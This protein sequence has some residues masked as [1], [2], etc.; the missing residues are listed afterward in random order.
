MKTEQKPRFKFM[1]SLTVKGLAIAVMTLVMLI[2]GCMVQD[3]IRERQRTRNEAVEKIDAKW[4]YAQTLCGPVLSIPFTFVPSGGKEPVEDIL[5][6]VP[7]TLD[8]STTLLPE[9]RH[10]GIY[11]T[12]LYK[13]ETSIKG[14]F[15]AVVAE[16]FPAGTIHWDRA[17]VRMGVTDLRGI[18][19]NIAFVFDGREYGV[20]TSAESSPV[21]IDTGGNIDGYVNT[22]RRQKIEVLRI[23]LREMKPGAETDFSC[24]VEL[25]GSG[26]INYLPV[27]RTTTVALTGEWPDPG[28]IG[29]YTPEY[30]IDGGSF[31]AKWKVLSFNR[32]IPDTWLGSDET[33]R[34]ASFGATLVD[35]VDIYQQNMRSSKYALMFIALTFVIFFFVEVIG[36]RSI[37]PV[38]YLLVGVALILFYSLLLSISE[39][40]G[41]GWAYLISSAATIG[42]ITA[43]AASIFRN[44]RLTAALSLIL[45]ALYVFMYVILQLEQVALLAGSVGLFVI[46]G[47]IMYFSHRVNWYGEK[48]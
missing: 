4:S 9:E 31:D 8:I 34:T 32:N 43:Y 28:F 14:S 15:P 45:V 37:H 2:P 42:L 12:I 11:K 47:I 39:P 48:E 3:L 17:R 22:A 36:R 40:L 16:M 23:D 38:Q 27:G 24:R 6:I 44:G 21:A 5:N 29:S 20:Q 19:E 13:S 26:S 7:L 30:T 41:F 46:L 18:S 10:Y 25:K 1:Q 35:T 33:V